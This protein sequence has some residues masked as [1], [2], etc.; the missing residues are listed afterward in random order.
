MIRKTAVLVALAGLGLWVLTAFAQG[1][2]EKGK[3]KKGPPG[4]KKGPP[5]ERKG[6]PPW[7]PGKLVPP[8]ILHMLE[9]SDEQHKQLQQ[10]ETEVRGKLM[11]IFTE[12]QKQRLQD[13][14]PMG[15]PKGPKDKGPKGK[16]P[17]GCGG[18]GPCAQSSASHFRAMEGRHM[19]AIPRF[20][21]VS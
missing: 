12:D 7:E 9:L 14:K 16:P 4:D 18:C 11:K 5:P 20:S 13:F 8:H 10:L 2:D 17:E 3:G 21:R 15:P 6:P 19:A 1:P